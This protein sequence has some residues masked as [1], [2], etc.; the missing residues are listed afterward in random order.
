MENT[1][2]VINFSP[3]NVVF[4]FVHPQ[5]RSF[6]VNLRG[7][8][9]GENMVAEA[10]CIKVAKTTSI[11]EIINLAKVDKTLAAR[12]KTTAARKKSTAAKEKT[13]APIFLTTEKALIF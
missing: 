11:L 8:I 13:L 12:E 6:F 9:I 10:K 4:P 3:K 7:L 1:T 5:C 2:K